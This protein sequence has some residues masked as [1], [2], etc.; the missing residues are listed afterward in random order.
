MDVALNP[1]L[2]AALLATAGAAGVFLAVRYW[3]GR[4]A[5]RALLR[6]FEAISFDLL[7][8]VL[9]P[10]GGGDPMHVDLLLL[11]PRGVLVVDLRRVTGNVFGS[12]GMD[13]WAVMDGNRR[14]ELRNPI[15]SLLDRVAAV[16]ALAGEVP[17]DG[18]VVFLPGASFPKGHPARVTPLESLTQEF[19]AADRNAQ[20]SPVAAWADQWAQVRRAVRPS[21]V[22]RRR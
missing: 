12:D 1:L 9:V 2:L 4:R 8:D 13:R 11:T 16:K 7:R 10:D 21:P 14:S 5:E 22:G 15:G 18:R 6:R 3:R 19:P 17:V 20:P